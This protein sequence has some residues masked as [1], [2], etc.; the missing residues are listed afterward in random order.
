[1]HARASIHVQLKQ[2]K[3]NQRDTSMAQQEGSGQNKSQNK[4]VKT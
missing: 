2:E 1:M 4:G 3:T